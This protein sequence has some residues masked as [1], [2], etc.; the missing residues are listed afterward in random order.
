M[1][2][3]F[4]WKDH[5]PDR[6]VLYGPEPYKVAAVVELNPGD[7]DLMDSQWIVSSSAYKSARFMEE[8][9][10]IPMEMIKKRVMIKIMDDLMK[11]QRKLTEDMENVNV[12]QKELGEGK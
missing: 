4:I 8:D 11:A 1:K 10:S 12:I 2:R 3:I 5:G 6:A 9:T 7:P